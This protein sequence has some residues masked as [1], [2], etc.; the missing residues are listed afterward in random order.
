MD[1]LR[2]GCP[3]PQRAKPN[4]VL[5]KRALLGDDAISVNRPWRGL[6]DRGTLSDEF[7]ANEEA[8]EGGQKIAERE[9]KLVG[10]GDDVEA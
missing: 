7:E 8:L 3:G 4:G 1:S 2:E 5:S 10:R 6:A 9:R